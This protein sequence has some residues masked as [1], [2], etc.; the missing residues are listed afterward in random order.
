[1]IAEPIA[2]FVDFDG[3]L[4]PFGIEAL[5]E[6]FEL[7]ANPTL[8]CW[9]PVLEELL[10]PH[11]EV[12]IIVS[13]DWRRLF[14]DSV[15]VTLLGRDLGQRFFG[16]VNRYNESRAA[17]ILAEVTQRRLRR[18]LAIDDHQTVFEAR[19]A[20]DE[21]FIPCDPALGITG[22]TAKSELR[23]KLAIVCNDPPACH[24]G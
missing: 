15:L 6:N 20:G 24:D 7:I 13:S 9:R 8:F 4:H 1:M 21:R 17:E 19:R 16:V 2:L 22:T 23:S 18:W 14:T 12:R 10:A 11:P 5:D 3:V